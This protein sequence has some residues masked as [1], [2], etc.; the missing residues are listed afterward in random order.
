[1]KEEQ[2]ERWKR[3]NEME[4]HNEIRKE[5]PT[6]WQRN[7]KA[8]VERIINQWKYNQFTADEIHTI[9]GILEVNSFEVGQ[10]PSRARAL[11][12]EAYLFA[13]DCQPNTTH[14]DDPCTYQL[15][16]R[17]TKNLKKDE[18]I[19]LS[20]S[21]TLQVCNL[22][23]TDLHIIV[24]LPLIKQGT[25]KRREHLHD[26]KFFWCCC[27]RCKDPKELGTNCSTLLCT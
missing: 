21:Y 6:I 18:I 7:Q 19:T 23:Y 24:Q 5:I 20:Y 13:H 27:D 9:C 2:P 15:T 14:T 10:A 4:A 22:K 16:V 11:Y 26:C 17:T 3:I 8:I 1:M 12:A 25:L